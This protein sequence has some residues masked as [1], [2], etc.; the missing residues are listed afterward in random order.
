MSDLREKYEL[1]TS[2]APVTPLNASA[3]KKHFYSNLTTLDSK[4]SALMAFDGILIAAA[5][6]AFPTAFSDLWRWVLLAVI[7]IALIAAGFCL[8]VAQVSY[9]FLGKVMITSRPP[10]AAL[11]FAEELN[12]LDVAVQRRTSFYR[13]AWRLSFGT[14]IVSPIMFIIA[15]YL[16]P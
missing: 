9:P 8:G 1:L 13:T 6:F 10:R 14:V 2:S 4:A 15:L 12:A 7:V 16:K 5:T 3:I 11:D